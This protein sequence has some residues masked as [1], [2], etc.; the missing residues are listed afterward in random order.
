MGGGIQEGRIADING[1][2]CL[3]AIRVVESVKDLGGGGLGI[4]KPQTNQA[5]D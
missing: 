5:Q 3:G 2:T 4:R 1:A